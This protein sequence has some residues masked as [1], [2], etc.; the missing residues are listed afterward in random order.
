M[1]K[2]VIL[3]NEEPADD[4][5]IPGAHEIIAMSNK[6][7]AQFARRA[8]Y[9]TVEWIVACSYA[10]AELAKRGVEF[11]N[12]PLRGWLLAVHSGQLLPDCVRLFIGCVNSVLDAVS[13]FRIEEQKKLCDKPKVQILIEDEM[14]E[15]PVSDLKDSEVRQVFSR[16]YIR[17]E[18]EQREYLKQKEAAKMRRESAARERRVS[19]CKPD[20]KN[21]VIRVAGQDVVPGDIVAALS[22]LAGE[23]P[24]LREGDSGTQAVQFFISKRESLALIQSAKAAGMPVHEFL[25]R[26]VHAMGVMG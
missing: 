10:C 24:D 7:L 25:R 11:P 9:K 17:S 8:A 16:T 19:K 15:K 18:T 12:G 14:I 2:T 23:C 21:R 1:S 5:R 3:A 22:A 6:D 13:T 4:E 26:C 20:I